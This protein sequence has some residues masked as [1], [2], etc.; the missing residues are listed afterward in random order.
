MRDSL[1]FLGVTG[2][3]RREPAL[4]DVPTSKEQGFKVTPIDQFWYAMVN[5]QG[6][7]GSDRDPCLS[8][9]FDKAFQDKVLWEQMQKAGEHRHLC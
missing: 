4:P 5:A 7:G 6:A 1:H 3:E 8:A 9:A 2:R